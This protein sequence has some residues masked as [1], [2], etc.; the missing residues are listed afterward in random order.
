M[1]INIIACLAQDG[2]IGYKNQL[3]FHI[4][5][6]MERFRTLTMGNTIIMGRKT[7]ESLP[8][9]ALPNRRNIVISHQHLNLEEC[10]VYPSIEEALK[11]CQDDQIFVIGGAS[12]YEQT[13]QYAT[14]LYLTLVDETKDADTFF[15]PLS[16]DEW[17]E[18]TIIKRECET[19]SYP[20]SQREKKNTKQTFFYT[21]LTLERAKQ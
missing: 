19:P 12:I 9:G 21:F 17:K 16:Q 4:K 6:D 7:Y 18:I 20:K 13:L 2:G 15:P 14:T 11:H 1:K 5:E 10:E 8:K 3:L